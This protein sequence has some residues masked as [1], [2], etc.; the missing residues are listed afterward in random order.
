MYI[1]THDHSFKWQAGQRFAS[2]PP[3]VLAACHSAIMT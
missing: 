3:D 1:K 2:L